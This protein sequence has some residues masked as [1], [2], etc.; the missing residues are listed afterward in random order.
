MTKFCTKCSTTKDIAEFSKQA[1]SKDGLKPHCKKCAKLAHA[2]YYE[3][4]RDT[5]V[6]KIL[7]WQAAHPEELKSYKQKHYLGGAENKV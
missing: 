2:K 1:S 6:K 7:E 3:L 5:V 4:N